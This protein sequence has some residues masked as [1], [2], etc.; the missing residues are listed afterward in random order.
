MIKMMA[1][2]VGVFLFLFFKKKKK[3]NSL[4]FFS[5]IATSPKTQALLKKAQTI[6]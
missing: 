6:F 4:F 3:K 2:S 5:S 1:W